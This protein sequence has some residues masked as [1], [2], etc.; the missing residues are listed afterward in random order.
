MVLTPESRILNLLGLRPTGDLAGLTCYTSKRGKTV[1]FQKAPPTCPPTYW[2]T[3]QRNVFRLIA[4]TW[5]AI[6][7]AARN[8]W[9]LAEQRGR[10]NITG[11]NLFVYWCISQDDAAIRT[12][13]RQTRT[14]LL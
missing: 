6:G 7:P 2:Q 4:Q 3:H 14:V 10:L 1:W 8:E 9:H 12:I 13:Q 11:F 5:N